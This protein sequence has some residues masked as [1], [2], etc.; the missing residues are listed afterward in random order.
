MVGVILKLALAFAIIAVAL[1][2]INSIFEFAI[3]VTIAK[4]CLI[5]TVICVVIKLIMKIFGFGD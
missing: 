4:I 1:Y 5:L 2:I 3:L